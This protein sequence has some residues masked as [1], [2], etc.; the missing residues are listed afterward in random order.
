MHLVPQRPRFAVLSSLGDM[1]ISETAA[2]T[3]GLRRKIATTHRDKFLLCHTPPPPP[4]ANL[5]PLA[6]FI[7]RFGGAMKSPRS[8]S[9]LPP[10]TQRTINARTPRTS[11]HPS[12]PQSSRAGDKGRWHQTRVAFHLLS[13]DTS[14]RT[15][16]IF[17]RERYSRE[18]GTCLGLL[19]CPVQLPA[20]K[21][22]A[23]SVRALFSAQAQKNAHG[24]HGIPRSSDPAT[25]ST[26]DTARLSEGEG[27]SRRS[28]QC[29]L[30]PDRM[31][32]AAQRRE[33]GY[34]HRMVGRQPQASLETIP[35][36]LLAKK[37]VSP[38]RFTHLGQ[39]RYHDATGVGHTAR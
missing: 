3:A 2:T 5:P 27:S 17:G 8:A 32:Q 29:T 18:H 12:A 21:D 19:C 33:V 16:L 4:T 25:K 1:S 26:P 14:Y 36:S 38:S 22:G 24:A 37:A 7:S 15:Y 30:A 6:G 9:N 23:G 31:P 34:F 10:P 28:C 20:G 13:R 39:P 11:Y 35:P